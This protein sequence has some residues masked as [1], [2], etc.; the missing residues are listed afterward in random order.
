MGNAGSYF[1]SLEFTASVLFRESNSEKPPGG[2]PVGNG[3]AWGARKSA[4]LGGRH[5]EFAFG[6]SMASPTA[7]AES[8]KALI[9]LV[10]LPEKWG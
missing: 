8:H 5:P 9:T 3:V 10:L 4:G 7:L 2:V 6:H 1:H